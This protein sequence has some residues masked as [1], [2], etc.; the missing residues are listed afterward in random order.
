M[1]D[2]TVRRRSVSP[3]T[4][5]ELWI[6]MAGTDGTIAWHRPA[7]PSTVGS[8]MAH[9][10]LL[11]SPLTPRST[12]IPQHEIASY[13]QEWHEGARS[14]KYSFIPSYQGWRR[15]DQ[16]EFAHPEQPSSSRPA[17]RPLSPVPGSSTR[18][19]PIEQPAFKVP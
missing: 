1:G 16:P 2:G 17:E 9:H 11:E 8:V 7:S 5:N 3:S 14:S 4:H 15:G 10:Q 12:A 6:P 18:A 19:E 13:S